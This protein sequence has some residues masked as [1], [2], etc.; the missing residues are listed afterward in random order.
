MNSF[1]VLVSKYNRTCSIAYW[2]REIPHQAYGKTVSQVRLRAERH[3]NRVLKDSLNVL[4]GVV[5]TRRS[6]KRVCKTRFWC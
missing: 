6:K 4:D 2:W 1:R 3:K 5:S